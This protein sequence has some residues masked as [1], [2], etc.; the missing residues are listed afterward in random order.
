MTAAG[1]VLAGLS[2]GAATLCRVWV[3]ERQDGRRLGFTDHD[4]DLPFMGVSCRAGS[5]LTASALQQAGGLSVDNSEA[6]G[7]IGGEAITEEDLAAGRYDGAGVRVWLV[8]WAAPAEHREIFRGTL[9]EVVRAGTGFRV[10]LRGLTEPLN[11]PQ[12][13]VYARSCSAVLGDGRCRFDLSRPGY[14][15]ER[16]VERIEDGRVLIFGGGQGGAGQGFDDRWFEG[17]RLEVLSGG[18]AGLVAAIRSDRQ[19]GGLRRLELWEGLRADVVPGDLVRLTAGCDKRAE[20]CRM[21]FNNLINF[22][23]F[24]HLP[25]EDWLTAP[26]RAGAERS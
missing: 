18:A 21:K 22:R 23:G 13:E 14:R 3:I 7:L 19:R 5:G 6:V 2:A 11:Q 12:G 8:D 26:A 4:G 10:E 15:L 9:G 17:G 1:G 16:A 20:T 24:P 25:G